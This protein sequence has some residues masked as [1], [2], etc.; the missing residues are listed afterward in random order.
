MARN[1]RISSPP[2]SA[3]ASRPS[4]S[5]RPSGSDLDDEIV[6]AS[7][8]VRSPRLTKV[9]GYFRSFVGLTLAV[10]LAAGLV[11]GARRYVRTSSRFALD[12]VAVSG[13]RR[14]SADEVTTLAGL[15]KGENVFSVDL[16]KSRTALLGD[17]WIREAEIV[18]VLPGSFQVRIVERDAAGIVAMPSG[19]V[20]VT[21]DGELIK[22]FEAGD[23]AALP[24]VTGVSDVFVGDDRDAQV[25]LVKRALALAIEYETSPLAAKFSLQEANITETGDVA[26][27]VG[28][29]GVR[30]AMGQPPYRRKI[31]EAAKILD[32]I[33]RRGGKADVVMLDNEAH[34]E[35]VVVRMR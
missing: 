22:R 13:N 32:E 34:P 15:R 4:L 14:R 1:R 25:A 18:R 17:P 33:A 7:S 26:L 3:S 21:R 8:A 11:W 12:E 2:P 35:R 10:S 20:L 16:A 24:V 27:V 29:Q 30:L 23:P 6:R 28:K 9:F 19:T 31:D 5:S